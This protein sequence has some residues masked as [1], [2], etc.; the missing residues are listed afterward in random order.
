MASLLTSKVTQRSQTTLPPGVRKVLD[1][2]PGE[3]VGYVIRGNKVELVNA[4]VA[5]DDDP[6]LDGFLEFIERDISEHPKHLQFFP[7]HLL[8]R[9]QKATRGV[10][11]DHDADIDGATAL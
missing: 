9:I 1:L 3:R 6:I 11:I 2:E 5:E 10:K 7:R 8:E 4:S